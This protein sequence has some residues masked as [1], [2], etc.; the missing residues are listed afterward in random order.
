MR[1]LP[2]EDLPWIDAIWIDSSVSE[3]DIQIP[4]MTEI[5]S[6]TLEVDI[7]LGEPTEGSSIVFSYLKLL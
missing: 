2:K 3:K 1:S 7:W 6:R 5:Y 4:L